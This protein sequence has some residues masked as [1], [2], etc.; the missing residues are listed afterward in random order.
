MKR[1]SLCSVIVLISVIFTVKGMKHI[2]KGSVQGGN[3]QLGIRNESFKTSEV[4]ECDR[5][6]LNRV[7]NTGA[8]FE[9]CLGVPKYH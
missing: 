5:K 7:S 3:E 1:M 8:R 4:V 9:V 6:C 2:V